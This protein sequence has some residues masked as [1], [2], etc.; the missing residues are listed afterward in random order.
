M[1]TRLC[2]LF[3]ILPAIVQADD[4]VEQLIMA[5]YKLAG[6]GSAATGLAVRSQKGE[7]DGTC[8]ILTAHHVL[9]QMKGTEMRIIS[10]VAKPNGTYNRNEVVVPIRGQGKDLW[11][12]HPDHDLAVL[13]LP[14]SVQL[15]AL[16]MDSIAAESQI[17]KVKAGDEVRAAVFPEKNES[18]GAGF[19]IIRGGIIASF[20][21][22]PVRAHPDFLVDATTWSG[23]SGGPVIHA[24]LRS[25]SG[26]P[27]VIGVVR[28]LRNIVDT[29]RESR[30]VDR[31]ERFPLDIAEVMQA[32]LAKAD[33]LDSES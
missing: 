30:F 21:L 9:A 6:E 28:G 3:L 4:A 32:A 29:N 22:N 10:R 33:L 24:E 2:S 18:N 23:D 15:T 25:E 8:F 1:L 20:P 13:A 11:K 5:T 16:G 14:N 27:L 31:K 26:G 17:E 19:P 7:G 12:K